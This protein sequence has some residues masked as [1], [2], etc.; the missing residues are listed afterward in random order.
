[1]SLSLPS[2][3]EPHLSFD[4]TSF[5]GKKAI[6]S[7]R[8]LKDFAFVEIILKIRLN[9]RMCKTQMS[10]SWGLN[11][12][13]IYLFFFFGG[14]SCAQAVHTSFYSQQHRRDHFSYRLV[15]SSLIS[16]SP[17]QIT[18]NVSAAGLTGDLQPKDKCRH[19]P[20]IQTQGA[21]TVSGLF[22]KTDSEIT[23]LYQWKPI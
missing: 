16:P 6:R 13:I 4:V 20:Y 18:K 7:P 12:V 2:H 17:P 14:T 15:Q 22:A 19:A 5:R 11:E 10:I 21:L 23:S 3:R 1:M 9:C 8:C